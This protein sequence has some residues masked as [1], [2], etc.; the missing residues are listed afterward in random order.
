MTELN[1]D[2]LSEML[3]AYIDGECSLEEAGQIEQLLET[4]DELRQEYEERKNV[5][6][7]LQDVFGKVKNQGKNLRNEILSQLP[8]QAQT[9]KPESRTNV[10]LWFEVAALIAIVLGM[11]YYVSKPGENKKSENQLAKPKNE[12]VPTVEKKNIGLPKTIYIDWKETGTA[13]P[14]KNSKFWMIRS[15]SELNKI[16]NTKGVKITNEIREEDFKA[17]MMAGLITESLFVK[18]G[19]PMQ[20]LEITAV[21]ETSREI[22]VNFKTVDSNNFA[23]EN[24]EYSLFGFILLPESAKTVK[25]NKS[26]K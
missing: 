9:T 12:K 21:L 6:R 8:Q 4:N 25:F 23:Q 14:E 16:A 17:K 1:N 7:G 20:N 3:Q 2:N 19:E 18:A 22:I 5:I 15:L 10:R 24:S 26:I 13:L 11:I